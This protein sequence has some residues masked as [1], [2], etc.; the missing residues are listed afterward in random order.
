MELIVGAV[1]M[2]GLALLIG[3]L[4]IFVSRFIAVLQAL[5]ASLATLLFF[6]LLGLGILVGLGVL[7]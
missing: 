6:V 1:P 4:I 7:L 5:F 3:L 2:G